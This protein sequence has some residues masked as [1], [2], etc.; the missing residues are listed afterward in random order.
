M[1]RENQV[2]Q[3]PVLPPQAGII[4]EQE[5]R[6]LTGRGPADQ[7]HSV[8][9]GGTQQATKKLT[10][11]ARVTGREVLNDARE[12][13]RKFKQDTDDYVRKN[14]AKTIFIALGIGFVRGLMRRR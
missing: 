5:T 13:L 10:P 8:Q 1:A 14:P 3:G 11:A 9:T 7:G 12:C 4:G 2:N 6:Q